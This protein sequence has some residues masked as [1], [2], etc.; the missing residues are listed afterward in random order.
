MYL[1][2][3]D[4]SCFISLEY[5]ITSHFFECSNYNNSNSLFSLRREVC[6][7]FPG[8]CPWEA[9]NLSHTGQHSHSWEKLP[10]LALSLLKT[11][12]HQ[13]SVDKRARR[14]WQGRRVLLPG[15]P[16]STQA[17]GPMPYQAGFQQDECL[18]SVFFSHILSHLPLG[19]V[20]VWWWL[21]VEEAVSGLDHLAS[22]K[23][24]TLFLSLRHSNVPDGAVPLGFHSSD[25][26][27]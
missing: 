2:I 1:G 20:M 18:W 26:S 27:C 9:K 15:M 24:L 17:W 4:I 23:I 10:A 19:M 25:F 11:L 13:S 12:V 22:W 6:S 21:N 8:H 16:C 3:T 14:G 7:F 5:E